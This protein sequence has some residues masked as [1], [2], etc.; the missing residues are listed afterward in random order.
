MPSGVTLEAAVFAAA[1]AID[2][3]DVDAACDPAVVVERA[4]VHRVSALLAHSGWSRTL[5]PEDAARLDE[6][7]R[8]SA[9]HA[10]VLDRELEHLLAWLGDRGVTPLVTKGAHLAHLVYSSPARRPR[11]DT[12]LLI[13]P[14]S[15]S[16]TM[17]VLTAHGYSRSAR[18]SGA[19]ILGQFEFERRLRSGVTHYVDVHWRP[20]APLIFER[21]FDL[22]GLSAAAAAIPALGPHA[23]GPS[24]PDALALACVHLVAHHWHQILL[25]WLYDIRLLADAIDE[26]GRRHL[27][28]RAIAGSYTVVL[29]AALRTARQYFQSAGLDR[30][31]AAIAP[32]VNEGEAAAAF[33]RDGRRKV[34]DLWL[35][36]R[37]APWRQRAQLLREHVLPP[38]DYMRARFGGPVPLAYAK[39]VLRGVRNWF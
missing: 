6:D 14:A 9:V 18:T 17:E 34:D 39:R 32:H 33:T 35:D 13:A 30:A 12:D 19:V 2:G 7:V 20:V 36:L 4:I 28:D 29:T 24:L 15:K 3:R 23:R 21:A 16:T 25:V 11:T 31:I 10:A 26:R 5:P 37:H 27:V 22:R 1:A 8:L 38:P